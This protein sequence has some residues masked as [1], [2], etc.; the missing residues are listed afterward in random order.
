VVTL[1]SK[2]NPKSSIGLQGAPARCKLFCLVI[3]SGVIAIALC[4]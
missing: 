4:R 2:K 3:W 1:A